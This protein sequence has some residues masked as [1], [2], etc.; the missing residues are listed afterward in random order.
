GNDPGAAGLG[1]YLTAS[2]VTPLVLTAVVGFALHSWFSLS[3]HQPLGDA[4]G[5]APPVGALTVGAGPALPWARRHDSPPPRPPHALRRLNA[6][7]D[8]AAIVVLAAVLALSRLGASAGTL[9]ADA[10]WVGLLPLVGS[11]VSAVLLVWL[12]SRTRRLLGGT[13]GMYAL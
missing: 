8:V 7:R 3:G 1:R 13:P 2:I 11:M 4:A 5:V 6:L 10:W 12:V 9:R